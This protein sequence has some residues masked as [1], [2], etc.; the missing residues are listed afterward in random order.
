MWSQLQATL[1]KTSEG[2]WLGW[3][4]VSRK[5]QYSTDTTVSRQRDHVKTEG[6]G[7]AVETVGEGSDVSEGTGEGTKGYR[8]ANEEGTEE[9]DGESEGVGR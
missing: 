1:G 5:V 9:R 4:V 6:N 2:T 7:A 8:A 3:T